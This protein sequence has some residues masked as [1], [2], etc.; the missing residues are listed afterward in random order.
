MVDRCVSTL[1]ERRETRNEKNA[2]SIFERIRGD[3]HPRSRHARDFHFSHD[4][5]G[6][7]SL[8]NEFGATDFKKY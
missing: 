6:I 4:V 7:S 1:T 5:I 8:M 2:K 3:R